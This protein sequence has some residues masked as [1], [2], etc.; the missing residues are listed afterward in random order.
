MT[1]I[2]RTTPYSPT[3]PCAVERVYIAAFAT[4]AELRSAS[5]PSTEKNINGILHNPTTAAARFPQPELQ[6]SHM[7]P[8]MPRANRAAATAAAAAA[9]PPA[10]GR[11]ALVAAA[12]A[13]TCG[14]FVFVLSF[15]FLVFRQPDPV[16]G[17]VPAHQLSAHP[18]VVPAKEKSER[19]A[20]GVD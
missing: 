13:V 19:S 3:A 4:A 11:R 16:R 2:V 17:A 5:T 7:V 1:D 14:F 18:A 10:M 12:V 20:E 9:V 15:V 8:C 6:L